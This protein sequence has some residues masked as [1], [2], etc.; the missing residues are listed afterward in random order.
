VPTRRLLL[1]TLGAAALTGT[2]LGAYAAAIEP[3]FRL[4]I[5]HHAVTPARWTPGLKLRLALLA[6]PHLAEP[7]MPLSRW[8]HVIATA[9]Q[10]EAD[11]ILLLGDYLAG[12]RFRTAAVPVADLAREA[13]HLAAPL[14]VH[15]IIGNH[16]WW[17][18]ARAHRLGHGTTEAQRA[19]EDNHIRVL[20]NAAVRLS[21]NNQ[22]FWLTGTDS[23]FA[24]RYSDGPNRSLR[25]ISRADLRAT[26]AQ[27]TDD[28][29]IIH[30]A[31]E[32]DLFPSIPDRVSLTLSGHT[33]GGQVRFLG[34][35][36]IVPSAY[37]NRYAYGHVQEN[38]RHLIVSG[39]LG[40]SI[41]PVRFGVPPEIT[42]VDV[43]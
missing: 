26:L 22:P 21:K 9:N 35:S 31:H 11:A 29:P 20:V 36:P 12:H 34:Y 13:K 3:G 28:A 40:C 8:R 30:L 32:P 19:L 38:G 7:L 42:V 24:I 1:Q 15:A 37:G 14:G 27:V 17:E 18:D 10:L 43:G 41:L 4:R 5:Q 6:D 39:G 16:D 23:I 33:H 2:S 25:Y